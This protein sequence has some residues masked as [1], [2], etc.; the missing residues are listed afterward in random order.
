MVGMSP[1]SLEI[2][3]RLGLGCMKFAQGPWEEAKADFERHRASFK[4]SQGFEPPPP[5]AADCMVCDTNL[6]RAEALAREHVTRYWVQLMHH[7]ELLSDNFA[8]AGA[9]YA[10]YAEQTKHYR[11]TSQEALIETYLQANIWGDPARIIDKLQERRELIGDFILGVS[12]SFGEMPYEDVRRS[13]RTF[14][15]HVMPEIK[16]W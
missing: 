16:T 12:P 2:A 15:D 9:A 11:A 1:Q 8:K 4:Q 5:I 3:G 6:K 14:V 13:L 7:Y 10:S